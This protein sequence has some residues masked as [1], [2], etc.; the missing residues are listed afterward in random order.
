MLRLFAVAEHGH[1]LCHGYQSLC[2]KHR[3][4]TNKT[5]SVNSLVSENLFSFGK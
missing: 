4:F 2:L 3:H 5:T 1:P